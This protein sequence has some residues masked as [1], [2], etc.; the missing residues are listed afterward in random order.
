[1]NAETFNKLLDELDGTSR[2]EM[3]GATLY[4]AGFENGEKIDYPKP[5]VICKRMIMNAGIDRVINGPDTSTFTS[6]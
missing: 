1:M 6:L 3:L 4:L 5:C 2:Q